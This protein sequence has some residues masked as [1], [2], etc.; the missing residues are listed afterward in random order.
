[1]KVCV[2]LNPQ[3]ISPTGHVSSLQ[4]TLPRDLDFPSHVRTRNTLETSGERVTGVYKTQWEEWMETV[5]P[6]SSLKHVQNRSL[7]F[8][9]LRKDYKELFL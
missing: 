6:T 7:T 3:E 9:C 8:F 4:L 5:N 1:M 2:L